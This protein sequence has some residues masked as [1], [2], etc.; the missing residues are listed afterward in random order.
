MAIA[1]LDEEEIVRI[2]STYVED[3]GLTLGETYGP[4]AVTVAENMRDVIKARLHTDEQNA[5]LWQDFEDDPETSGVELVGWLEAFDEGDPGLA[6]Q[7]NGLYQEFMMAASQSETAAPEFGERDRVIN[8]DNELAEAPVKVQSN[9]EEYP[10]DGAY[11]YGDIEG[12]DEY[13][14]ANF[15]L[16]Y[17][18]YEQQQQIHEAEEP[19]TE[20]IE[21]EAEGM[22]G[23]FQQLYDAVDSHP[24]LSDANKDAVRELLH[25]MEAQVGRGSKANEDLLARDVRQVRR[26]APDIVD[27]LLPGL[28]D[29]AREIHGPLFRALRRIEKAEQAE[30]RE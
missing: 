10:E 28:E 7:L 4:E 27:V 24:T 22:P 17:N 18:T 15:G 26:L 20:T 8:D 9:D 13:T 21:A 19:D 29:F 3:D 14:G 1:G 23:L 12:N 30:E 2:L 6:T 11:V 5:G 16:E 25:E